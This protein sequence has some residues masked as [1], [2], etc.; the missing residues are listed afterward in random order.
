MTVAITYEERIAL[1]RKI[2]ERKKKMNLIKVKS[3]S[4]IDHLDRY[5][6]APKKANRIVEE[7]KSKN[8]N[9]WTDAP[10]YAEKYYGE[11]FRETTR[12]DNDWN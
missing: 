3:K 11:T 6:D 7:D 2:A 10:K 1:I 5:E 8:D 9:Y 12:F 4:V